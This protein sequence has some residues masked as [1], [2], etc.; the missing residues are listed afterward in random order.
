VAPIGPDKLDADWCL[1][2]H[3]PGHVQ[4]V[5]QLVSEL[6]IDLS[7]LPVGPGPEHILVV[8]E[9]LDQVELLVRPRQAEH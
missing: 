3:E 9:V 8:H 7:R 5:P 4:P 6:S 2:Q 1:A